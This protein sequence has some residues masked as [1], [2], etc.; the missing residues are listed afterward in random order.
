MIKIQTSGKILYSR[1]KHQDTNI[2]QNS[3]IKTQIF[4]PFVFL[5]LGI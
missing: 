1:Y 3:I 4:K 5:D 2:K